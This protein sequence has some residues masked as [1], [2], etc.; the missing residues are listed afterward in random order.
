MASTNNT[1]G[2]PTSINLNSVTNA[3]MSKNGP[4]AA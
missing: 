2:G 4:V 3:G 1:K